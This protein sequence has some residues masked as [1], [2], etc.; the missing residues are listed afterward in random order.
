MK[1]LRNCIVSI[2]LLLVYIGLFSNISFAA[3]GP[4][5]IRIKT[6]IEDLGSVPSSVRNNS[7][8]YSIMR[9][10]NMNRLRW[11]GVTVPNANSPKQNFSWKH[12]QTTNVSFG[13]ENSNTTNNLIIFQPAGNTDS[14]ISL[15]RVE[16]VKNTRSYTYNDNG[17]ASVSVVPFN[18]TEIVNNN[19]KAVEVT[20]YFKYNPDIGELPSKPAPQVEYSKQIDYLG[21]GGANSDTSLRGVND[22]RLYLSVDTPNVSKEK[23]KD[24]IF[25]L[26][27]SSSMSSQ[28]GS[29]TRFEHMKSTV[30]STINTLTQNPGNKISII[31]FGTNTKILAT[32]S[33]SKDALKKVVEN[34]QMP[35]DAEGG[36]NYYAAMNDAIPII[37]SLKN[38]GRETVVFFN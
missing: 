19:S 10:V 34:M 21:D 31:R 33:S 17:S 13:R 36:T 37:N 27:V 35:G 30:S 32:K 14:H 20:L 7:F 24:I 29:S 23:D 6:V 26:D 2:T 28:L 16:Y 4:A 38:P 15:S 1:I 22:Y 12:N 3:V 18:W 5:D 8:N 11:G 9:V 25:L